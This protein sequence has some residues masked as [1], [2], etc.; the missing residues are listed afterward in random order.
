MLE[1]FISVALEA[2]INA[3]GDVDKFELQLRRKLMTYNNVT[4]QQPIGAIPT[5]KSVIPP[6]GIEQVEKALTNINDTDPIFAELEN[7]DVSSMSDADVIAFARRLGMMGEEES[8]ESET[9]DE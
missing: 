2:F 5:V 1:E 3:N 9:T 8:Q 6:I 7:L 4:L